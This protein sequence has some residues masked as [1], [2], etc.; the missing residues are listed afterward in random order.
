MDEIINIYQAVAKL[1][2]EIQQGLAAY[3]QYK[4]LFTA[5]LHY[6]IHIKQ[7]YFIFLLFISPYLITAHTGET[8][9]N[10]VYIAI[11][12][13][14]LVANIN[15]K[16]STTLVC[17]IF[18]LQKKLS[19][20]GVQT[21]NMWCTNI[22]ML[23]VQTAHNLFIQLCDTQSKTQWVQTLQYMECKYCHTDMVFITTQF[24]LQCPI[25]GCIQELLG[26][27][28][29][30][31]HFY[32]HV[33]QKAKSGIFIP[34]RHYRFWI[35]HILGTNS[36]QE[37][38]TKQDPCGT[39]VLQQLQKIIMRDI[40]CIALL[41]VENI[42]K[43]L[44]EIYRT[45]LYICVSLILR[46]LTGVRPPQISESILLR[47]EYI[48]TEAIT[49]REKVCTKGRIITN[50]YPY[51]I[52]TIFVAILPPNVTTNR[53]ILQYIHLQGNVTLP[54]IVTVWE[55]ICMELPAIQ[56]KPTDRTHCVHFFLR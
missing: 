10:K 55:S 36:E 53:R 12:R 6:I 52:Y 8:L 34:I 42:R 30:A 23:Q 16:I 35:Q 50:Y 29:V 13:L 37:L 7:E 2:M 39:K 19:T 48:F 3:V 46:I 4:T 24:G 27:I 43:M 33:G 11:I 14:I 1:F 9:R 17:V 21:K 44:Q 18:L 56:W 32:N 51:Y 26:T 25:C 15:T 31:T 20:D 49:I 41:S 54:I 45:D 5:M 40:I 38:G 22:P 28:F 47:G